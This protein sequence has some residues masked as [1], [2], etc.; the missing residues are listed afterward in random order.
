[1]KKIFGGEI[2]KGHNNCSFHLEAE[3]VCPFSVSP[4]PPPPSPAAAPPYPLAIG[5]SLPLASWATVICGR[6]PSVGAIAPPHIGQGRPASNRRRSSER[7][8]G[9]R[10]WEL[11]KK[12]QHFVE[13]NSDFHTKRRG[14]PPLRGTQL[15][16]SRVGCSCSMDSRGP[17]PGPHWSST[18]MVWTVAAPPPL[19]LH[20]RPSWASCE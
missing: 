14:P 6:L 9:K 15:R 3:N 5:S 4:S 1:M 18:N 8:P 17:S 7:V 2:K 11:Q 10:Q 19:F 20:S 12:L 13:R 16:C